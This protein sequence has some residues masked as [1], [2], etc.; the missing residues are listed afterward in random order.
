MIQ[1]YKFA[2][3]IVKTAVGDVVLFA[4]NKPMLDKALAE[5]GI[6]PENPDIVIKTAYIQE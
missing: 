2:G 5:R 6:S 3:Y 1:M 4:P